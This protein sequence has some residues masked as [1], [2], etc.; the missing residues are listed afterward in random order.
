[1]G[2]LP[3]ALVLFVVLVYGTVGAGLLP[4]STT[5]CMVLSTALLR[6]D[7]PDALITSMKRMSEGSQPKRE[8]RFSTKFFLKN[9]S[10][11]TVLA[12]ILICFNM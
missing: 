7:E 8:A 4:I 11:G 9:S 6:L 12:A 5:I 3:V 10:T 2:E 1:M